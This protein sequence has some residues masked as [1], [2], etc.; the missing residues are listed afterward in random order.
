MSD[1]PNIQ[2]N[3][4]AAPQKRAVA[5]SDRLTIINQA[6][7]NTGNN[8]VNV[9]DDASSEWQVANS[10][11]D[12]YVPILYYAR[13]WNFATSFAE[14]V[15][16]GDSK[17]PGMTDEFMRPAD[18]MFLQNVW[19]IDEVQRYDQ[20]IPPGTRPM[21]GMF[22]PKL[23][24]KVLNDNVHTRAPYGVLAEYTPFPQANDPWSLGF[25]EVLRLKIEATLYRALNE[26]M[27]AGAAIEKYAE[28]KLKE[29][30]SRDAQETPGKV[31]FVSG[32]WASRFRRKIGGYWR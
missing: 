26:D 23:P 20:S 11:Y 1:Y 21:D 27:Q 10:A 29:A 16:L 28:E 7:I 30:V 19:R 14:L 31:M 25:I 18:C 12:Q 6:L 4:V 22:P 2:A 17:Y 15:R 9:Y 5:Q 3:P 8:T 13:D 24:Y 32:L